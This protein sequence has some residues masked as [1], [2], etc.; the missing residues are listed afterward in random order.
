[1]VKYSLEE[2]I[3][4]ARD[5]HKSGYNCSQCVFMIF[6]DI[7]G[8]DAETAAKVSA[9][10]RTFWISWNRTD[11]SRLIFHLCSPFLQA[12]LPRHARRSANIRDDGAFLQVLPQN[13]YRSRGSKV[14]C[15]SPRP[16]RLP[17]TARRTVPPRSQCPFSASILQA[18]RPLPRASCLRCRLS[19]TASAALFRRMTTAILR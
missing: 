8:M 9:G 3:N 11:G 6:D 5:L 18:R 16:S 15:V 2:R 19:E 14:L 17:D 4:R 7:H 1:M 12:R 13:L 10:C